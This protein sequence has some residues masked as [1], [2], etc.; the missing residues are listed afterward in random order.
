MNLRARIEVTGMVQ[1]VGYRYFVR[2][3]ALRHGIKGWVRNRS[4]GSV[5]ILAEG[6]ARAVERL[7]QDCRRGPELSHVDGIHVAWED[8]TG[9]VSTDKCT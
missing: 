7:L 5:E 4:D 1:G 8:Y 6:E 9:N 3:Q 2:K